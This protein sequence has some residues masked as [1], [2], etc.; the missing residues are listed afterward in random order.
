MRKIFYGSSV[1]KEK[2]D[3]LPGL[4]IF[5]IKKMYKLNWLIFAYSDIVIIEMGKL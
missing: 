3:I 2:I 5:I 1:K 4:H